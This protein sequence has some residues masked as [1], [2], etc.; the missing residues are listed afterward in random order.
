[1]V[2]ALIT[3]DVVILVLW[4]IIETP[5][6]VHVDVSYSSVLADVDDVV[7]STGIQSPFEIVMLVWKI[8]LLLYGVKLAVTT[9]KAPPELSEAKHF[10]IA[11]YN[12]AV[13]GGITYFLGIF[14]STTNAGAGILLH[15]LGIFICSTAAV[16]VIILPKLLVIEGL[17][18]PTFVPTRSS[19][20]S[21]G[22]ED[23]KSGSFVV[24]GQPKPYQPV[25]S[26]QGSAYAAPGNL[27]VLEHL[28]EEGEGDDEE[29]GLEETATRRDPNDD[30]AL[31]TSKLPSNPSESLKSSVAAV[32]SNWRGS[33]RVGPETDEKP[34]VVANFE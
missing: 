13:L 15:C 24:P 28:K 34:I 12:I 14:I 16:A 8:I 18:K 4:S 25:D 33:A 30:T 10:A 6:A 3:V 9:W 7:C 22:G 29:G 21:S 17:V 5:R 20:E 19:A 2:V 31:F 32:N 1:M 26:E 11:I 27:M 23:N